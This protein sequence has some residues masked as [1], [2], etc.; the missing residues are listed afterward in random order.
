[1]GQAA[2]R[3]FARAE[4]NLD[5][6]TAL[7]LRMSGE[8]NECRVLLLEAAESLASIEPRML[9]GRENLA[10]LKAY[11]KKIQNKAA[12]AQKLFD[13]ALALYCGLLAAGRPKLIEY[14][15]DWGEDR[16]AAVVGTGIEG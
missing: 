16:S 9:E 7:L 1:M 4:Q 6:V 5:R 2:E 15:P 14:A 10:E 13:S 3:R 12:A 11:A 8:A